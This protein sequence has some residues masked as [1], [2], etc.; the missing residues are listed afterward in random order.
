MAEKV[1]DATHEIL[2][3]IQDSIAQSGAETR[4]EIA[5]LRSELDTQFEQL[6]VEA[7]KDRRNINGLMTLLQA[8]SGDFDARIRN[9]DGRVSILEDRAS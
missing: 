2:K 5:E 4:A 9:P 6:A 1:Q 7:R 8:A 3:R